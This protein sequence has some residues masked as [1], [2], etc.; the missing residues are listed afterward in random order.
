MISVIRQI[1]N[2]CHIGDSNI[3]V[4]KYVISRTNKG[5]WRKLDKLQRKE[6]MLQAIKCHKENRKLYSFIQR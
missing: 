3:S 5:A 2:R 4:I 6:L 1:V